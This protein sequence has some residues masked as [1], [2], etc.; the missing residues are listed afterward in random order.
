LLLCLV[1]ACASAK[2][3]PVGDHPQR[4][5][6]LASLQLLVDET[7]K[8]EVNHFFACR[9][10]GD[11][12]IFWREGR[13]LMPTLFDVAAADE[14]M[15]IDD[16]W[17]MRIRF[18]RKPIDLDSGVVRRRADVGTSTY[19]VSRRFVSGILHEC[20]LDGELITL[21]KKPPGG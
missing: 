1:A 7:A 10:G 17:K 16:I 5:H 8:E 20:V 4:D 13:L 14:E 21:K 11:D 3:L 12:W 19:F 2:L 6:I 9:I 18:C 15:T